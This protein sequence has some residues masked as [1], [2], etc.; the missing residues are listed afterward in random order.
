[1]IRRGTTLLGAL[2]LVLL[3]STARAASLDSIQPIQA[4]GKTFC[5]VFSIDNSRG[6]WGTAR[7]CADAAIELDGQGYAITIAGYYAWTLDFDK[8]YDLAVM[9]SYAKRPAVR[10]SPEAPRACN[11]FAG[12]CEVFTMIGYPYGIGRVVTQ[13][14]FGGLRFDIGHPLYEGNVY[15]DVYDIT[16][17]GGNS[18]SPIFNS[19]MEVVGVL[20]GG[21]TQS[22]HAI[23]VPYAMMK[24]FLGRFWR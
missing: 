11:P 9:K 3:A 20:W 23:A 22:P 15:S 4:D 10:L 14:V 5:T 8:N 16:S 19:H 6:L 1:M 2:L 21:F 17:A 24:Q 18:G 13:G 7:H 12:P